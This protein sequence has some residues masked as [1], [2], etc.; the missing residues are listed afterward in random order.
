MSVQPPCKLDVSVPVQKPETFSY[1]CLKKTDTCAFKQDL[2]HAVSQVSS[3]SDYNNH[4]CSV[5]DKHA[6]LCRCTVHTRKPTPV[7]SIAEQFCQ[8]KRERRQAERR[9]LKSKLTVREQIYDSIKQDVTN[10]VDKARQAF[11]SAK[12]QSSTTC[13][14]IFQNFNTILGKSRSSPLPSTF[15]SD[16]LP[17]VFSD[18]FTEKIRS[19]RKNFPPPNPTAC[20]DTSFAGNPLLTFEPVTDE[21]VLKI[22]NSASAKS[23]EL[24]P[25]PT[26]LLY[27]NRDILLPTITNIINIS[28]TTGIVPRDLMTAVVKPLLKKSSLYKN[29]LKNYRPISNLPFLS[30]ILEKVVLH[31][32][33]PSPRKQSQQSLSVSLLSRTQ[34]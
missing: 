10:L 30:K 19:I 11:Y 26:T 8:L 28:L 14:Q 12:I 24:Y 31:K 7:S 16:D 20:P 32:L 22:F 29:L 1:R 21:F 15:D 27:E 33:L 13:K 25:I 5:L 2:S 23:C 17:N 6:P 18:Y 4:L 9:W 34:Q 3:I